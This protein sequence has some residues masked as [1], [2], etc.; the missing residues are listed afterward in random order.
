MSAACGIGELRLFM[1]ALSALC[2]QRE[3][4]V[5]WIAPPHVPY[6]PALMQ[7]GLE[8]S[9]I[10][11]IHPARDQEALWAME[12]ALSSG[13][14]VAVLA[15]I[16][17][18]DERTSRRLQLAAGRGESWAIAFRPAAARREASA[19]ALRL[20]LRPGSN[21]TDVDLFKV[22]GAR[23]ALVSD[24]DGRDGDCPLPLVRPPEEGLEEGLEEDMAAAVAGGRAG[25]G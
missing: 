16:N 8:V 24:Y 7:W 22:R 15:W 17:R 6:A 3:G 21:G 1:P 23:P 25:S 12:Q 9:R 13:T 19:A 14:C 11:L 20:M 5:V 18:M 4:W 2:R 10:L